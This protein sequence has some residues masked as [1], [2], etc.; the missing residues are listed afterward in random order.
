MMIPEAEF[1]QLVAYRQQQVRLHAQAARR[2]ATGVGFRQWLGWS[3]IR[4]GCWI[5]GRCPEIVIEA[6]GVAR[7]A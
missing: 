1:P 2:T 4:V 6:P 5:E 3:L 7:S